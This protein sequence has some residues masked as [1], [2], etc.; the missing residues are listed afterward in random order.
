MGLSHQPATQGFPFLINLTFLS[1]IP[2]QRLNLLSWRRPRLLGILQ[3]W[4]WRAGCLTCSAW[5]PKTTDVDWTSG[6]CSTREVEPCWTRRALGNINI[7]SED[8]GGT[9]LWC[10]HCRFTCAMCKSRTMWL[11]QAGVCHTYNPPSKSHTDLASRLSGNF[12]KTNDI[13]IWIVPNLFLEPWAKNTICKIP[14]PVLLGD[15]N[16]GG[17]YLQGF[18]IYLHQKASLATQLVSKKRIC[19]DLKLFRLWLRVS[20]GLDLTWR[21]WVRVKR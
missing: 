6:G 14:L 5:K 2:W 10:K 1:E 8:L 17:Y 16:F 13:N 12:W 21:P 18:D 20:S 19:I 15:K 4:L 3:A 7:W 9:K 11:L